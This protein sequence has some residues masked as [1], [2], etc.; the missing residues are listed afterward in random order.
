VITCC[1]LRDDAGAKQWKRMSRA[2]KDVW[3][4]QSL[5]YS[6]S[7]AKNMQA[8]CKKVQSS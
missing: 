4:Q 2:E 6:E 3:N 1:E 7:Y 5:E 8:I